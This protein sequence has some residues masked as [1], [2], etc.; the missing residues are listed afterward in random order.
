MIQASTPYSGSI[1][2]TLVPIVNLNS[3]NIFSFELKKQAI[4]NNEIESIRHDERFMLMRQLEFFQKLNR[5]D[6]FFNRR[7]SVEMTLSFLEIKSVWTDLI[8]FIFQF[9]L[10]IA[11]KLQTSIFELSDTARDNIIKLKS[12]G[13]RLWLISSNEWHLSNISKFVYPF[14]DGV[15]INSDIF[16]YAFGMQ[17][18]TQ[19]RKILS[20]WGVKKT[21]VYGLEHKEH[22]AFAVSNGFVLGQ[23]SY[24]CVNAWDAI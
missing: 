24:C 6:A 9:R 4:N 2:Y 10:N 16:E 15:I 23:G 3:G 11:I 14:F 1:R 18:S 12:L 13:V 20:T 17:D 7:L 21:I 5:Q 8:P 19:L 22:F